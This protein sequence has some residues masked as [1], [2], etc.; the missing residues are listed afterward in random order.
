M[1]V[2]KKS[3]EIKTETFKCLICD[4]KYES[5]EYKMYEEI[6]FSEKKSK[7][8]VIDECPECLSSCYKKI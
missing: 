3:G 8:K 5:D 4:C 7:V 2:I 1:K 6:Y